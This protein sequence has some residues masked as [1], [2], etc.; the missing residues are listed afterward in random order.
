[1]VDRALVWSPP[2]AGAR[3]LF[4]PALTRLGGGGV[5]SVSP[6]SNSHFWDFA[7]PGTIRPPLL[8]I[9]GVWGLKRKG[10]K[11]ERPQELRLRGE[12]E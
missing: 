5:E 9:W 10:S 12:A 7:L 11:G 8:C 3:A 6:P 2:G 4:Y 1:M